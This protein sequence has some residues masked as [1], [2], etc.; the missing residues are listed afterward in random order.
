MNFIVSVVI[1]FAVI[2]GEN[3]S[4]HQI[5]ISRSIFHLKRNTVLITIKDKAGSAHDNTS[6]GRE[7]AK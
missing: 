3:F 2:T 1:T 7:N 6:V 5:Y 4:L